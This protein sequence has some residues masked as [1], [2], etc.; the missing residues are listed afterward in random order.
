MHKIM[1][2]N[3]AFWFNQLF[4]GN[5]TKDIGQAAVLFTKAD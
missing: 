2:I 5:E 1:Q 3:Y 4:F